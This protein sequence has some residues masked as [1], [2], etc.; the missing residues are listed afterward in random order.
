R[1][2][3]ADAALLLV[4]SNLL[5]SSYIRD[6]E[7][8]AFMS[9]VK[10][11]GFHLFWVLLDACEWQTLP[12]LADIQATGGSMVPLSQSET[13]ADAQCRLIE[14]GNEIVRTLEQRGSP[15]E[16]P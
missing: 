16:A 8:P 3:Q 12:G 11:P 2:G 6:V 7:L 9:K 15:R 10:K 5:Q 1:I 4:S 14:I 13:N